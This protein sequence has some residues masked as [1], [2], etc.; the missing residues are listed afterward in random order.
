[1]SF[2]VFATDAGALIAAQG[3]RVPAAEVPALRDAAALL[4]T[5]RTDA[6]SAAQAHAVEAEAAREAGRLQGWEA[7][8]REAA[9][10]AAQ[11]VAELV[12]ETRE[13]RTAL[14][15]RLGALSLEVVRRVA[16]ELG[17]AAVLQ[18]VAE[19]A[20]REVLADAPLS[21]RVSP[22]ATGGVARRL[23]ALPEVEVTADPSLGPD[24]CVVSSRRGAAHAGLELQLQA[25]ERAF[26]EVGA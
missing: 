18:A 10:A 14:E 2:T 20:A 21:V 16:G 25:L 3:W 7:G 17:P 26:A 5:L 19:R 13:A 15:R 1:M 6:A 8:R 12:R 22:A 11:A 23:A 9:A 4:A 24:D